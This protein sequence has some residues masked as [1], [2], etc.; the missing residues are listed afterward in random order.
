M[1]NDNSM[2]EI[3]EVGALELD[4]II[5]FYSPLGKYWTEV[6]PGRYVAVDNTTGDAWTEEFIDKEIMLDW[7]NTGR[8][9]TY[10]NFK[11]SL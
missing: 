9:I 2:F 3:H 1:P 11:T 6:T 7:L 5:E 4:L 8:M 10:E